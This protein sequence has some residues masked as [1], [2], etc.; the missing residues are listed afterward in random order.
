MC[1]VAGQDCPCAYQQTNPRLLRPPTLCTPLPLPPLPRSVD[2]LDYRVPAPIL[3]ATI[4]ITGL[5]GMGISLAL[6]ELLGDPIWS[7]S[8]GIGSC[9]AAGF[10]ELGRPRRLSVEVSRTDFKSRACP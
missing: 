10:Y 1:K 8:T 2:A 4:A 3:A 6:G 9:M 5:A 7:V